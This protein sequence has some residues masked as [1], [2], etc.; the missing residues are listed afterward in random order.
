MPTSPNKSE[1]G[2]ETKHVEEQKKMQSPSEAKR[3][4]VKAIMEQIKEKRLKR[5]ME[6]SKVD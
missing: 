3:N 1:D 6:K 2:P 5:Q 4:S